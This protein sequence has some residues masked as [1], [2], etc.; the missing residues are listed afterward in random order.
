MRTASD[1][2]LGQEDDPPFL[3]DSGGKEKRVGYILP[4]EA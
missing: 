1:P 4:S 3:L 2:L